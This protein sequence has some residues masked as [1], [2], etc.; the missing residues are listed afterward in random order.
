MARIEQLIELIKDAALRAE[1]A[2]EVVS[3]KRRQ[4]FGL[5]FERH[6]PESTLL[7]NAPIRVGSTVVKKKDQ[8]YVP[9][10]V[11][12][13]A[14]ENLVVLPATK[15]AAD[16]VKASGPETVLRLDVLAQK[17]F[18]ETVY[19][20]LTSVDRV[21]RGADKPYHSVI[22]G[23]N[24]H[25]LELLAFTLEGTVDCIYIDPPYNT[26]ATHWKYNNAFV[27][28]KDAW[29]HSK[30]LAFL[31]RR[32]TISKRLLRRDGVLILTIDKHE[33]HHVGMLLE[34]V[35][36]GYEQ[37]LVSIV[38]NPKGTNEDNFART[39]EYAIFCVPKKELIGRE[40]IVGRPSEIEDDRANDAA[41]LLE[42]DED[43]GLDADEIVEVDNADVDHE[44]WGLIRGGQESSKRSAR[45]GQFYPL[46]LDEATGKILD[47]G[48]PLPPD[49]SD[50]P[51]GTDERGL[52]RVYP[53]GSDETTERV[54]RYEPT[55][56]RAEIASGAVRVRHGA[57][58]R[59]TFALR[60]QRKAR[61][62]I[63]TS[64]WD[65]L[66]D[67]GLNGSA[68]LE[69]FVPGSGFPFPKSIYAVR[70]CLDA[71]CRDRPDAVIVDFFAGS[72]TTLHATALM[73]A[74]DG[75]RRRSVL[76]TNNELDPSTERLLRRSGL[77]PGDEE[78]DR[79]GIFLNVTMPRCKAAVIGARAD[80][81]PVPGKYRDRITRRETRPF[82]DGFEENIEFLRLDYLDPLDVELGRRYTELLPALWLTAGC[83]GT[84]AGLDLTREFCISSD[85]PYAFLVRPSGV[86]GLLTSLKER[87]DVTHV[88]I[89]TDSEEAFAELAEQLPNE[90]F[91]KMLPRDYLRSFPSSLGVAS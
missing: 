74:E 42:L 88:F 15:E 54:W 39:N 61:K 41:A 62:R 53:M 40:V 48:D 51:K 32:L 81:T 33:L 34:T 19:P 86:E 63:R 71:V 46:F 24:F 10:T 29:R 56:M 44:Y 49:L 20:T 59:W 47:V 38:I 79:H 72:G 82:A 68:I 8:K 25:A 6:L 13:I 35:F 12:E 30:F 21:Q 84:R 5:V 45:P 22:N 2:S 87:P 4:Q 58:G 18:G 57:N 55:R 3:L 9:Y 7:P 1:I 90:I 73:N 31:E 36:P 60:R 14:D 67:A 80:G 11:L 37:H 78:Y 69:R 66:H 89:L 27:D 91:V 28:A 76:V 85:G 70:D 26:G 17:A 50:Y 75:G 65:S 52:L 16:I 83:Y 23:E 64:W 77:G 43:E